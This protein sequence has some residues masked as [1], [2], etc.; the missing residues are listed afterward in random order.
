MPSSP[1]RARD[2]KLLDAID[3]F[4]REPFDMP[5]W[6]AVRGGR[7]PLMGS[8]SRSRWCDGNFDVLY[9]SLERDGAVAEIHAL[10]T[11]QP[12]FP[13]K[14]SWFAH[15]LTVV[16]SNTLRLADLP[17]L[18][19]LGV[20]VDRYA[21]RNYTRTQEIADASYFLGFDGLVVPSARWPCLNL[22]LFTDR[23]PPG[24][25]DIA[26]PHGGPVSWD[27]WR[28]RTRT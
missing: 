1:W 14:I 4:K 18:G 24:Q 3:A 8:P 12:V 11:L 21:E 2:L 28:K 6:R 26:E 17:T 16:A 15:E 23:V 20:D 9:T 5:V 22:V 10:L 13:S 19:R 7:D 25:I 27:A